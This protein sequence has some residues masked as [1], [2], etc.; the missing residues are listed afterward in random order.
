MDD[1]DG[2]GYSNDRT[3]DD[4]D[5]VASVSG[6]YTRS[7]LKPEQAD[8]ILKKLISYMQ[9]KRP[10]LNRDLSIFD[11]AAMTGISRHHITQVLNEHYNRNFYTFINEFRVNE[12]A[13]RMADAR[14]RNYTILA[15]AYD[16]GFNSKSAF[17]KIFLEYKGM[18]PSEYRT[19]LNTNQQH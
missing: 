2:Q 12:A 3:F 15:I 19:S 17:N 8:E 9:E 1:P 11:L 16:S 18:T 6:R 7:G 5:S 13:V 14:F 4:A 10:Y